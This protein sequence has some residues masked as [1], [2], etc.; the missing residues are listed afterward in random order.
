MRAERDRVARAQLLAGGHR[1]CG[2]LERTSK[3]RV[4]RE[5]VVVQDSCQFLARFDVIVVVAQPRLIVE[6]FRGAAA[7]FYRFLEHRLPV[8]EPTE[9]RGQ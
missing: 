4:V 6:K 1:G 5:T 7:P 8:M 3:V 9:H 2:H